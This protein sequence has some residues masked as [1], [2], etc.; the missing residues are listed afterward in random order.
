VLSVLDVFGK[1]RRPVLIGLVYLLAWYLLD[2]AALHFQT[3]RE[4]SVWYPPFALDVV[5][6]LVFGLRY[7]PLL[8]LNTLVH[9][10]LVVPR[11]LGAGTLAVFDLV[12]TAGNAGACAWLLR[13]PRIDPRLSHLRDVAWFVAV[14]VIGM[15]FIVAM[16]Q[17]L[18]LALS[19]V[20]PWGRLLEDTLYYWAGY[21]TGVGL[22][23]PAL[24]IGLRRWPRLWTTPLSEPASD[25][26]RAA[27]RR[28]TGWEIREGLAEGSALALALLAAY[29]T[30]RGGTLDYTYALFIPLLWIAV[31]HG[32]E[33]S[34]VAVLLLNAGVALLAHDQIGR[35]NG[36]ALQFGLLTLTLTGLL[37]GAFM[38]ERRLLGAR[39]EHQ[40]FH[41]PLTNLANRTLFRERAAHAL[42]RR[43]RPHTTLAVLFVDLDNFKAINDSLG[44]AVGDEVLVAMGRRL[45][46]CVR[47]SDTVARLGGDEFAVLLDDLRDP[48]EAG[49]VAERVIA[50]LRAPVAV[51]DKELPLGSSVGIA[52]RTDEADD[53]GALLRNADVALYRAK[54]NGRGDYQVFD[55]SMHTAIVER[56][57]L[58]AAL[59]GAIARGELV[60]HYQPVVELRTGRI[61]GAEALVRWPHP[62]R[63]LLS[64]AA[65]ISLAEETGLIVPL[66]RWALRE[67]CR[68][69]QTWPPPADG[70]PFLIGVNLSVIHAQHSGV[71][72]DVATALRE[73]GLPPERLILE[74]T[75]SV[76][77]Q[78][79]DVTRGTLQA[80]HDLGVR[81]AIDDFGTGYSSLGYLRQFPIDVLKLDRSFV[82][83]IGNDAT[84]AALVRVVVELGHTLGLIVIAEGIE[85]ADQY[86]QV[87]ALGCTAGQGYYIARPL[88]AAEV[89][90]L[91][92]AAVPL[93]TPDGPPVAQ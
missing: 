91:M 6:L 80:L 62:T 20:T 90:V 36:L 11:P 10:A 42:A 51:R 29:G 32:F 57:D 33:R 77:V 52:L 38:G 74:V 23:A 81:L 35:T 64:P 89:R 76:L 31:R 58:E 55:A 46:A 67:A 56:L 28:P 19:G 49:E 70:G 34:A 8:L 83:G 45:A 53:V 1:L 82:A 2:Q 26:T 47:P 48:R 88:P 75:E 65:F 85:D 12:T 78:D 93:V 73:A 71:A 5:L 24:L 15:P 54:A 79:A 69:A 61:T 72:A 14:A 84:G 3:A 22:L 60:L 50:A 39:L 21:A 17:V 87:R 63:G 41:D 44:H 7:W 92:A 25:D 86:A 30:P 59:R 40:A 66:G 18:N 43:P 68:E 27:R 9:D 4:I 37:L 13:G 16:L